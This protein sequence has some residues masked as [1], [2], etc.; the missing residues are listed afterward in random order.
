MG[1]DSYITDPQNHKNAHIVHVNE[2]NNNIDYI[3]KNA[4]VVATHPLKIYENTI[5]FFTSKTFGID[6]NIGRT[7]DFTENINDGG[8][9][10]YWTSSIISGAKWTL[11]SIDQN[12]TVAGSFSIK[13]DNDII[14]AT[15][16]ITNGSNFDLTNFDNLIIWIYVDVDWISTDSIEIYGWDTGA[17]IIVGNSVPLEDY[18]SFNIFG[19]WQQI[20]IPLGDMALTGGTLDALRIEL[21]ANPV[22]KA[23]KYY[24]DD[25]LFEGIDSEPGAGEF[26]IEPELGTWLHVHSFSYMIADNDYDSTIADVDAVR[27]TLPKIPYNTFLGVASLSSGVLY[28][29]VINGEIQFSIVIKQLSD[30]LQ[31]AGAEISAQGSVGETGTWIAIKNNILEPIILKSENQDKLRFIVNDNLSGLDI[32]RITAACKIEQRQ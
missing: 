2:E 30:I 29:R 31:L 25:I 1:I 28:Q 18:F 15:L 14:N 7:I 23:P 16:Q 19:V 26:S 32:L 11:S 10:V 6:M 3:N 12:H 9:N 8:D 20:T 21:V 4:L 17:G 5:K 22:G 27:P 13:S 24:L